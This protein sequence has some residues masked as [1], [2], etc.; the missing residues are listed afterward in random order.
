MR[1]LLTE[2]AFFNSSACI[3]VWGALPVR[4][5]RLVCA[6]AAWTTSDDASIAIVSDTL[7]AV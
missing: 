4:D 6:A 1:V 7:T 5:M 2:L 3:K